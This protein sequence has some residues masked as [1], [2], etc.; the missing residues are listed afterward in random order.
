MPQVV[1]FTS[2]VN[3]EWIIGDLSTVGVA[4][5]IG[6]V[7]RIVLVHVIEEIVVEVAVVASRSL[8]CV[9]LD[10]IPYSV[11][12]VSVVTGDIVG[13]D[14]I[15]SCVLDTTLIPIISAEKDVSLA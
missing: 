10:A 6:I 5:H 13:N 14:I 11:A 8:Y 3:L 9:F 7:I 2:I 1:V 12:I 15:H 4:A